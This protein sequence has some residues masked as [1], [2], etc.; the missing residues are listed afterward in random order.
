MFFREV[1]SVPHSLMPYS[2]IYMFMRFL[3]LLG[4]KDLLRV[5]TL[6]DMIHRCLLPFDERVQHPYTIIALEFR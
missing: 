2:P 1:P 6:W 3:W 4:L 5:Q